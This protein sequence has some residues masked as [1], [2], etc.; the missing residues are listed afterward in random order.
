MS[1]KLSFT[2]M[3]QRLKGQNI[4]NLREKLKS[5]GEKVPTNIKAKE[6]LARALSNKSERQREKYWKGTLGLQC[7]ERKKFESKFFGQGEKS[8]SELAAAKKAAEKKEKVNVFLSKRSAEETEEY[9]RQKG[10]W[11]KGDEYNQGFAGQ[12]A[13]DGS[14]IGFA[15][16]GQAPPA[17]QDDKAAGAPGR[18]K[19]QTIGGAN[20]PPSGGDKNNPLEPPA[21][22]PITILPI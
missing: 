21:A 20:N 7:K 11:Y 12:A 18:A 8:L 2:A 1:T 14:S 4:G 9:K 22:P 15:G 5:A 19:F 3:S 6:V 16:Q 13:G 17:G 10:D